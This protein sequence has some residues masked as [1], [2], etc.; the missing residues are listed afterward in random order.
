MGE[1][2]RLQ[3]L[4]SADHLPLVLRPHPFSSDTGTIMAREGQTIGE[5][6]RAAAGDKPL[7]PL[8]VR[9]G[10]YEVPA[11]LWDRV[12]PKR[13]A[14]IEVT[15]LPQ[16]SMNSNWRA[17]LMIVVTIV[18]FAYTGY[19][20]T[21]A[22]GLTTA[23]WGTVAMMAASVAVNALV[24]PPSPLSN[25]GQK[26][27]HA[28]TGNSNQINPG[29]PIPHVLGE[30]RYFPPHAAMP[31]M[32]A[33]GD[34]SYQYCLFD[35]GYNVEAD[36][37]DMA[38][39]TIGNTLLSAYDS[40]QYQVNTNPSL[41]RNDAAQTAVG[42]T[43]EEDDELIRTTAPGTETI[44][45][46]FLCPQGYFGIPD[47]GQGRYPID[48]WWDVHYRPLGSSTWLQPPSPRL[49]NLNGAYEARGM[50]TKN[51]MWYD[52]FAF[53]LAWDVPAGQ[54]E[55]RVRRRSNGPKNPAD[56]WVDMCI[57]NSLLSVRN[58]PASRT[59]TLKIAMRIR[60]DNQL[61]G[62]L[63]TFS[64]MVR[65]KY[66][67]YNETAGTWSR[68][69]TLNAGWLYHYL[70][71]T[72]PD[73]LRKVPASRINLPQILDFVDFCDR[74]E[75][76]TRMVVD[77]TSTVGQV[78][79]MLLRI[80]GGERTMTDGRYGVTFLPDSEPL[81][82]APFAPTEVKDFTLQRTFVRIPHALRVKFR[83]P[84]AN[85]QDDEIIVLDDGYSY[86][87]VDARG[88]ASSLPEPMVF[89]EL[90][91][92]AT[93][94]PQQA[95]RM[96]RM[97]V[98]QAKFSAGRYSWMSDIA[99]LKLTKGSP[100]TVAHDVPEWGVG[101][102]RVAAL[103]AGGPTG[104]ATLKL[105][106][107]IE[108]DPAKSYRMQIRTR[109][110]VHT[111]NC[112]PHSSRTGTFYLATMPPTTGPDGVQHG[113]VAILGETGVDKPLLLV[114]HMRATSDLDFNIT[115][116]AWDARI[117]PFWADPPDNLVSEISGR[118]YLEPPDAPTVV[119]DGGGTEADDAGI[120]RP[121]INVRV[122]GPRAGHFPI[123]RTMAL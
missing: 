63:Q 94:M 37:V 123:Y 116:V 105:E 17:V 122:P 98:A 96:G 78:I 30:S 32:V 33:T 27:W 5:M 93:I 25:D 104:A 68:Q 51:L 39:A 84:L 114:T 21:G 72:C 2:R 64:V 16:G 91:L 54:Y 56:T 60:A 7:A 6:L 41:Y 81:A 53:G 48:M 90:N 42:A 109:G 111:I 107:D 49:S 85:W 3:P 99:A 113:H 101:Y 86:R 1:K 61:N 36:D 20:D 57:W 24:K 59:G 15:G 8:E 95:W 76:E 88:N 100:C 108:T 23:Q 19:L 120:H 62:T 89:E 44:S 79:D 34:H 97:H 102:G 40:V 103:T 29:G 45:L 82:P 117:A 80:S 28:L 69:R 77:T 12:R 65:P 58:V 112:T 106:A 74:H 22:W 115:G 4:A 47:T 87:G 18:V 66:P 55:V 35:L 71:T 121:V 46:D 11:A 73:T 52:P 14:V 110:A 67:V 118:P 70:L 13:G 92:Q 10:G 26:P 83:N 38:T 43:M 31:Y 75:L 50:F 9:V 119:V